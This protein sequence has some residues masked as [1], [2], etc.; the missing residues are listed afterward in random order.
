MPRLCTLCFLFPLVLWGCAM[1]TR[2]PAKAQVL[3]ED[4]TWKKGQF[5]D[6]HL[7]DNWYRDHADDYDSF[8]RALMLPYHVV[9]IGRP[10]AQFTT[11]VLAPLATKG[12]SPTV[13]HQLAY[14]RKAYR[15]DIGHDF[16]ELGL[17]G[18]GVKQVQAW[19]IPLPR[20]AYPGSRIVLTLHVRFHTAT[21]GSWV[22][23]KDAFARPT[24]DPFWEHTPLDTS[25]AALTALAD[26]SLVR[27]S[28]RLLP[29]KRWRRVQLTYVCQGT[30]GWL[31]LSDFGVHT[32][33]RWTA[34]GKPAPYRDTAYLQI[35]D[36]CI[37]VL[38]A[39]KA[40]TPSGF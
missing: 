7:P 9:P 22:K 15:H 20:T 32:A 24:A 17:S 27:L 14:W 26:D 3:R 29:R 5:P 25:T 1:P 39:G 30:Y 4:F 6:V 35:D 33:G 8:Y 31:L 21:T 10:G 28:R 37:E 13:R 23:S 18:S 40:N 2:T 38:G 11:F 12:L 36:I 34:N 16:I 19:A